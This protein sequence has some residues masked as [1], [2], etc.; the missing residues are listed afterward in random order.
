MTLHKL[1]RL[2]LERP[3]DVNLF[4]VG[5]ADHVVDRGER[6]IVVDERAEEGIRR[7]DLVEHLDFLELLEEF[8]ASLLVAE[9][10][11]QVVH[12]LVVEVPPDQ[13]EVRW[14]FLLHLVLEKD[15]EKLQVL[16]DR[17]DL[18]AVERERLFQLV[19]DADE[20]EDEAVRLDH[21]LGLV[22]VGPVHPAMA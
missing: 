16:D 19:E 22:L 7:D 5:L 14:R 6:G 20:V 12:V 18:V 2:P 9:V 13:S 4:R 1:I 8:L 3:I 21:L 15:L 10:L 17:I 11:D